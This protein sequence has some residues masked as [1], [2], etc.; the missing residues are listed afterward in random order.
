[1]SEI[2]KP[3]VS[4]VIL[5]VYDIP[6]Y[7]CPWAMKFKHYLS[8]WKVLLLSLFQSAG[9]SVPHIDS[10]VCDHLFVAIFM[11]HL[12]SWAIKDHVPCKIISQCLCSRSSPS[13][14]IYCFPSDAD[15]ASCDFCVLCNGSASG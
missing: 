11:M 13:I 15:P 4:C 1:M 3:V 14:V 7:H 10:Q 2:I 12:E 5:R 8:E 6:S 9:H